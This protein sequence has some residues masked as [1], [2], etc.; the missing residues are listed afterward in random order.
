MALI[1]VARGAGVERFVYVSLSTLI[2]GGS[3][4]SRAKRAVEQRLRD[5]PFACTILRPTF[6]METWL[7]PVAGFDLAARRVR[8]YGS[9]EKRVRLIAACDVAE[10]AAAC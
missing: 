1:D 7:S 10:V 2:D 8:L 6:L 4:L 5:S 9:G 3:P